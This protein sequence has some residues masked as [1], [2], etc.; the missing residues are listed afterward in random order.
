MAE[1]ANFTRFTSKIC[2][3]LLRTCVLRKDLHNW[4]VILVNSKLLHIYIAL[5]YPDIAND[6]LDIT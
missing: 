4:H 5:L 1:E 2:Q 6:S 3:P